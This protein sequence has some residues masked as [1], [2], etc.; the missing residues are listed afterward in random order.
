MAE[1]LIDRIDR[2]IDQ[3]LAGAQPAGY[4]TEAKTH[5]AVAAA[6]AQGR[7]DWG[8][9]LVPVANAAGIAHLGH[10]PAGAGAQHVR[11]G[12]IHLAPPAVFDLG[13]RV[14]GDRRTLADLPERRGP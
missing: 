7:A 8:V 5:N 9:A 14:D 12:D 1:A 10:P 3:L 11:P 2:T 13:Q 6:V 4:W